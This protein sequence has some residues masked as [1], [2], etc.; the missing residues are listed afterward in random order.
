MLTG[1][2]NEEQYQKTY[3]EYN[4]QLS[5]YE[6]AVSSYEKERIAVQDDI[7]DIYFYLDQSVLVKIDPYK[8]AFAS[9]DL[10]FNVDEKD[11]SVELTDKVTV[12]N[13]AVEQILGEYISYLI[14]VISFEE[15]EEEYSLEDRFIRELVTFSY[16]S[17]KRSLSVFVKHYSLDDAEKILDFIISDL[18]KQQTIFNKNLPEHS[19]TVINKNVRERVDNQL[20]TSINQEKTNVNVTV[21]NSI[22]V[23]RLKTVK[24]LE[25]RISEID[26]S[27]NELNVNVPKS[28]EE[29]ESRGIVLFAIIGLIAGTMMALLYYAIPLLL[30]GRV[31]DKEDL[32]RIFNMQLLAAFPRRKK[33]AILFDHLANKILCADFDLSQEEVCQVYK[34]EIRR[35]SAGNKGNILLAVG[36]DVDKND[37]AEFASTIKI[38]DQRYNHTL[39]SIFGNNLDTQKAIET[40]DYVVILAKSGKTSLSSLQNIVTKVKQYEKTVLGAILYY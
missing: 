2:K 28:V 3:A 35:L 9:M 31:L 16:D 20:I 24:A 26:N 22:Y 10:V 4:R 27:L 11:Y 21:L 8:E 25:D 32:E 13:D 17:T 39:V 18:Q 29:A 14:N 5:N 34:K 33:K 38:L 40:C 30:G 36:S 1:Q 19:F 23:D 7:E 6:S 15:L 37:V 12:K